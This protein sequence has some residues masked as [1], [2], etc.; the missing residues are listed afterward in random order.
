[1]KQ[2]IPA[3]APEQTRI[4]RMNWNE[5]QFLS[6]GKFKQMTPSILQLEVTRL[7]TLLRP[8]QEDTEFHN[9]LIRTRFALNQFI[10]CVKEAKKDDIETACGEHLRTAIMS[11]SFPPK[12][13]D[14]QT[15]DT[16]SYI[17]ARLKYV[18]YRISLIY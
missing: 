13:L 18:Y 11:L 3:V 9:Q 1:M 2:Q 17:L 10:D 8:D 14:T 12:D 5:L 15:Q 4:P 7:G 16:S 6:W